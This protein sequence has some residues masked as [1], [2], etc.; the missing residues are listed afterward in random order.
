MLMSKLL[1]GVAALACVLVATVH[2]D[3]APG[4]VPQPPAQSAR[5]VWLD[6][7]ASYGHV[8]ADGDRLRAQGLA[9]APHLLLTPMIYLGV[10]LEVAAVSGTGILPTDALPNPGYIPPPPTIGALDGT[11]IGLS[12]LGGVRAFLGPVSGS[13]EVA[14][15]IRDVSIH[16][17]G[18]IASTED[19][20][21]LWTL[22]GRVD[23]WAA[24]W[25][26]VGA[27]AAIDMLEPGDYSVGLG[28]GVHFMPYD[29]SRGR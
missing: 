29:G 25:L 15:G 21:A 5:G 19:Y 20:T 14:V 26:T 22:R 9:F 16:A 3:P 8:I 12:G 11:S 1:S 10:S 18:A 6:L 23:Y 28:V 4:M 17:A 27:T 24:P 7:D 2:A 13:G